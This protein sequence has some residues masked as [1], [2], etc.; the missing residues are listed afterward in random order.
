V[1][2]E[3]LKK[4]L[5]LEFIILPVVFDY[6]R[7]NKLRIKIAQALA[8]ADTKTALE[9]TDIGRRILAEHGE[10][11]DVSED[12]A[13]LKDTIQEHSE[14]TLNNWLDKHSNLWALR[15]EIRGTILTYLHVLRNTV[16]GI[17]ATS[18]RRVILGRY[19]ANM[20]ALSAMIDSAKASSLDVLLYIVPLRNDVDIPYMAEEY[21]SFKKEIKQFAIN[22]DI[23]FA[24]LENLIPGQLWGMKGSTT[25]GGEPELDFMHFQIA[26]HQLLANALYQAIHQQII[27]QP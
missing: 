15:P 24:N 12:M 26:G 3:Y 13:A 4:R 19:I 11:T 16:F 5:P 9:Q 27:L 20:A 25:L 17:K 1:L 10:P 8:D 18:K 23:A 22:K 7:E 6:L 21:N 2:F 14:T